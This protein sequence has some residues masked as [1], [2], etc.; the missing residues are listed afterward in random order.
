MSSLPAK[1]LQWLQ[2]GLMVL[3]LVLLQ[4]VLQR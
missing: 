2:Q 3:V 1:R 4:L